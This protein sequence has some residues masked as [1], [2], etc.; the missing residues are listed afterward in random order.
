MRKVNGALLLDIIR[1]RGRV[2]RAELA[3]ASSLTKPTVSSQ[4]ADLIDRG[5]VVEDGA[6]EP[7]ERG[8]KPPKLL[9][10]NSEWGGLMAAE[11]S[12]AGIRAWCAD[13]DGRRLDSESAAFT[14]EL[15][16]D[17]VLQV[18]CE[19]MEALLGRGKRRRQ[20][21]LAMAVA[22]PGRVDARSGV[23]LEAGIFHWRNVPVMERI[24]RA[25]RVPVLVDNDVNL[26]ALGEMHAGLAQGVDNFI[27]IRLG[28]GVGA[29]VVLGRQLYRGSHWAAGE[30]GHMI[31][32]RASVAEEAIERGHLELAIGSD[33]VRERMRKAAASR[34][35]SEGA[36][37]GSHLA[38]R[39]SEA[40]LL[41]DPVAAEV[42]DEVAAQ[43]GVAVADMSAALDPELVVL[44]GELFDLVTDRIKEFVERV[45]P[46][47][48][49]IERSALGEDAALMGAI[50]SARGIAH[51]LLCDLDRG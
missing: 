25:F 4:V 30:I 47:P 10:F 23:V 36:T 22:A 17:H 40:A 32:D 48:V 35:A 19:A 9:R 15:G 21:L 11:I 34:P 49:R 31:F 14:P 6:G 2:S 13:L 29:G 1:E 20:K 33:R 44:S 28:T 3:R 8:G 26:A 27:L 51:E 12:T 18:T 38:A 50:G 39:L 42:I 24:E 16:P 5:V 41:N 43:L 45:I 37:P 46:W 7:D